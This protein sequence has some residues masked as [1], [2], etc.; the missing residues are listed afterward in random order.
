MAKV[1]LT[2]VPMSQDEFVDTAKR[3][4]YNEKASVNKTDLYK[5]PAYTWLEIKELGKPNRVVL[6]YDRFR[7][8][9]VIVPVVNVSDGESIWCLPEQVVKIG[10]KLTTPRHRERTP[11]EWPRNKDGSLMGVKKIGR[12]DKRR[13]GN[14]KRKFPDRKSDA[15]PFVPDDFSKNVE[16]IRT[17]SH[18]YT[19]RQ[20]SQVINRMVVETIVKET[21]GH[22]Y[23][24]K[25]AG[26][27][28]HEANDEG[29]LDAVYYLDGNPSEEHTLGSQADREASGVLCNLLRPLG[30]DWCSY[31]DRSITLT[32]SK[33]AFKNFT[34]K[35][36]L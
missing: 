7:P 35:A 27:I 13:D 11:A 20:I 15:F 22:I 4:E 1:Q 2:D 30:V 17:N 14:R 18:L 33:K 16:E 24:K 28:K 9:D 19:S 29:G 10:A 25:G 12:I 26:Y 6:M 36:K 21:R 3:S 34:K 32:F 8:D 5:V 23:A 31:K